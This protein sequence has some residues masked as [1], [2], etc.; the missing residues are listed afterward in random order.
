MKTIILLMLRSST[1]FYKYF[2]FFAKNP[3]KI[4]DLF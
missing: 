4:Q 2:G 3:S 1:D